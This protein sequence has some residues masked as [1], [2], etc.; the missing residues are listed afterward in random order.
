MHHQPGSVYTR[1]E[2]CEEYRARILPKLP[3]YAYSDRSAA[4]Y[5]TMEALDNIGNSYGLRRR[6]VED[7][8]K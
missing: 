4:R 5:A 8:V 2:T 6:L 7:T 1:F 3:A